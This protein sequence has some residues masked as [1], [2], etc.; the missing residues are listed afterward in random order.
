MLITNFFCLLY[1]GNIFSYV[2]TGLFFILKIKVL[3]KKLTSEK[4]SISP[5]LQNMFSKKL[6]TASSKPIKKGLY[7]PFLCEEIDENQ[8]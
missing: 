6:F 5:K 2:R 7:S 3:T 4:F 8:P 1:A